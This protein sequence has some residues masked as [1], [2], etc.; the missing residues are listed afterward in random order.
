MLYYWLA[1]AH[2]RMSD[3]RLSVFDQ[4]NDSLPKRM[5]AGS[6]LPSVKCKIV[7]LQEGEPQ[8][9][10]LV[11]K[12][13]ESAIS[14]STLNNVGHASAT[15]LS[16]SEIACRVMRIDVVLKNA[17]FRNKGELFCLGNKECLSQINIGW[18]L[19]CNTYRNKFYYVHMTGN[20]NRTYLFLDRDPRLSLTELQ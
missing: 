14:F 13:V 15:K 6:F 20:R 16:A 4:R 12:N 2:R 9:F 1:P 19:N 10:P 3:L 5:C 17:I 11:T 8:W 7:S 18:N